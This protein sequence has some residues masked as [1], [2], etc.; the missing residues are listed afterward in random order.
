MKCWRHPYKTTKLHFTLT[1]NLICSTDPNPKC[2]TTPTL[3]L[4]APLSV[5]KEQGWI[6]EACI[7]YQNIWHTILWG[8]CQVSLNIIPISCS[9]HWNIAVLNCLWTVLSSC[10]EESLKM[11]LQGLIPV[12]E[13]REA[14][15]KGKIVLARGAFS[16]LYKNW[17]LQQA[18]IKNTGSFYYSSACLKG[19]VCITQWVCY[20][21]S[22]SNL[23]HNITCMRS[24]IM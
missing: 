7:S 24:K 1:Y 22:F 2:V 12:N 9:P 8:L 4:S 19:L 5:A 21:L 3:I 16:P 6:W 11:H 15:N 20:Y 18:Q 13:T 17:R 14:K 10:G 23:K